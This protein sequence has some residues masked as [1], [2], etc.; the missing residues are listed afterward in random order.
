MKALGG[1]QSILPC[2]EPSENTDVSDWI[3]RGMGDGN[4]NQPDSDFGK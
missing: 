3:D 2:S 4:S 1:T